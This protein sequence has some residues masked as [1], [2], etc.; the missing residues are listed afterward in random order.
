MGTRGSAPLPA[1]CCCRRLRQSAAASLPPAGPPLSLPLPLLLLCSKRQLLQHLQAT[2]QR[3]QRLHVCAQWA[4]KAKAVNTCR[5]VLKAAAD[6][7]AAF[8]HAGGCCAQELF[9]MPQLLHGACHCIEIALHVHCLCILRLPA[10]CRPAPCYPRLQ[11]TSFSASMRSCGSRGRPSL[12]S[13]QRCT[14]CRQVRELGGAWWVLASVDGVLA[15][16]GPASWECRAWGCALMQCRSAL[17]QA[18]TA[19]CPALSRRSC[20]SR[21][22]GWSG[23]GSRTRRSRGSGGRP[24]CAASTSCCAPNCWR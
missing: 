17:L 1:C 3:L 20:S 22:S 16:D 4:H 24:R 23:R 21:G 8:V 13:A 15:G 12:M 7:G 2:R 9:L 10:C 6:H 14:S 19:C 18:L 5:E 11:L